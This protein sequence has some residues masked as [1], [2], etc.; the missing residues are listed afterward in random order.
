MD[1]VSSNFITLEE[2]SFHDDSGREF[3]IIETE[4]EQCTLRDSLYFKL[5][6]KG[7]FYTIDGMLPIYMPTLCI[8]NVT[9]SPVMSFSK[10]NN[11]RYKIEYIQPIAIPLNQVTVSSIVEEIC[12]IHDSDP[13]VYGESPTFAIRCLHTAWQAY[14]T[15]HPLPVNMLRWILEEAIVDK[16]KYEEYKLEGRKYT[17]WTTMLLNNVMLSPYW[18]VLDCWELLQYYPL[19]ILI[20]LDFYQ[21]RRLNEF[22]KSYVRPCELFLKPIQ[23]VPDENILL[24]DNNLSDIDKNKQLTEKR[25]KVLLNPIS[26]IYL[27]STNGES[28]NKALLTKALSVYDK[29]AAFIC[30]QCVWIFDMMSQDLILSNG[31]TLHECD[32]SSLS[33]IWW[34]NSCKFKKTKTKFNNC[35]DLCTRMIKSLYPNNK[36]KEI[37]AATTG[38]VQHLDKMGCVV[39]IETISTRSNQP[40]KLLAIFHKYNLVKLAC[41]FLIEFNDKEDIPVNLTSIPRYIKSVSEKDYSTVDVTQRKTLHAIETNRIIIIEGLGGSGKSGAVPLHPLLNIILY[42]I[43]E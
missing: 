16:Q 28:Q 40:Q 30:I 34:A 21:R 15:L 29:D 9:L 5:A 14:G 42:Y 26:L 31:N 17:M 41:D 3:K 19:N 20:P 10:Y 1:K 18:I 38:I 24:L 13:N 25:G 8:Y 22:V 43:N 7:N 37:Y 12:K 32:W 23:I 4:S 27:L 2:A 11:K 6:C 33:I 35:S 39:Q 36:I